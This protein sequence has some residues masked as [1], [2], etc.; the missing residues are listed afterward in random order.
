MHLCSDLGGVSVILALAP[1]ILHSCLQLAHYLLIL[2]TCL[3]AH[4]YAVHL[5]LLLNCSLVDCCLLDWL[6]LF[7]SPSILAFD[8]FQCLSSFNFITY[9]LSLC[10]ASWLFVYNLT[11][12]CR[13]LVP[14]TVRPPV[15]SFLAATLPSEAVVLLGILR[16]RDSSASYKHSREN[17]NWR[18][19]KV[20][21]PN[22][23]SKKAKIWN[24]LFSSESWL[25]L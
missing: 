21:S 10:S 20:E 25:S 18:V 17:F 22:R 19:N 3:S 4:R 16:V 14:H 6:K 24:Q 1:L 8:V 2:L 7:F 9:L 15:P 5:L 13:S 11:V 23:G 12:L